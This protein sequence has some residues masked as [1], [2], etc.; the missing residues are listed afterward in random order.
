MRAE[1]W[2]ALLWDYVQNAQP[3]AWGRNDCATWVADWRCICTGQDAAQAW[4]GRYKTERGA[5]L[6][7]RRAGFDTMADWVDS[8]LGPRLTTPLL[9]Q[10]GD[11]ALVQDALGIVVGAQIAALSPDGVV[12]HPITDA[13]CAWRVD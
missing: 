7:I 9:A 3:F 8:I 13:A 11:I 12:Y 10:R 6:A 5:M 4:R 2:D 1:N